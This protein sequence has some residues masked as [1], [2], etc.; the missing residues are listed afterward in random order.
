[1]KKS[2]RQQKILDLI[3]AQNIATQDEL[4]ER[5]E[6]AG[7]FINQSSISRDLDE[8]GVIKVNGFYSKP[9]LQENAKRFGLLGLDTAGDNLI[10][11]K[12]EPGLASAVAVQIDREKF[13][14]I[15]G[16]L[17]GDDT[18]FIA[19]KNKTDQKTVLKKLREFFG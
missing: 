18:I 1:M 3:A 7:V 15:V 2:K 16:T 14:E 17:A 11:A 8:L 4:N 13:G 19:V 10:A 5:L 12:C 6:K 9:V